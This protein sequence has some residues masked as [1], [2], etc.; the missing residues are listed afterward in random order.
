MSPSLLVAVAAG[1]ALGS[2]LRYAAGVT[3]EALLGRG[4]PWATLLVNGSGALLIG[5]AWVLVVERHE[6]GP[7][8]Q[9]LFLTGLLGGFTTF[10]A[11]SL[12]TV[13]LYGQGEPLKASLNVALNVTVCLTLT[14]AGMS[15]ARHL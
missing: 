12:E 1:G 5:L 2:M 4:F 15:L 8:W 9:G 6:A 7:L 11:F 3:V 10:S 13:L 14:A